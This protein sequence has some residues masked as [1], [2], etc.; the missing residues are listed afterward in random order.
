[1]DNTDPAN[2]IVNASSTG[3]TSLGSQTGA[4]QTFATGTTGT[5]FN[6]SSGSNVHT[7][8]IPSASGSNRG[9]VTTSTQTFAGA[10]TF[11][12]LGG[13]PS[14]GNSL[15]VADINGRLEN[16]YGATT[17]H[18]PKWNGT[19]FTLQADNTG[20]TSLG[21]QT[22][23]TQTFATANTGTYPSW[24]SASNVHTYR[25][26]SASTGQVLKFDGT[27]WAAGTDNSGITG[28]STNRI[29]YWTSSTA[30]SFT[31]FT[32]EAGLPG[33]Q[34]PTG[35]S[36]WFSGT[37]TIIDK[38]NDGGVA[39]QVLTRAASGGGMDW[40]SIADLG[41]GGTN[42]SYSTKSGTDVTLESS[43]GVDVIIRDGVGTNV[44]RIASNVIAYDALSSQ[45][46]QL[47]R[48]GTTNLGSSGSVTLY[49][50]YTDALTDGSSAFTTN[51]GTGRIDIN[52]NGY[53]RITISGEFTTANADADQVTL[54]VYKN[55]SLAASYGYIGGKN[56]AANDYM[57]SG[58]TSMIVEVV[59]TDYFDTRYVSDVTN[60]TVVNPLFNIQRIK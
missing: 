34:V 50:G 16:L 38:N 45:F 31:N 59:D 29:P 46:A 21:S 9:L 6:I 22:G 7:F 47:Y 53:V 30:Q 20:I 58:V 49:T 39:D 36:I 40:R 28:G 15:I 27:G 12:Y 33:M 57:S 2:P 18:V 52:F 13:A 23:A 41:A 24:S 42:L 8:N 19:A 1:V 60:A 51:T 25:L 26:P 11:S 43:T 3:I 35:N 17:G 56:F 44:N 55:A 4:T 48:N 14:G 32:W 37:A 54:N 5:D 10:K